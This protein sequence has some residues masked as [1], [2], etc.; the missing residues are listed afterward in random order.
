M[1]CAKIDHFVYISRNI[2]NINM[3]YNRQNIQTPTKR[4]PETTHALYQTKYFR[5]VSS[6]RLQ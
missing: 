2:T 4:P 5:D 3:T 6:N 1:W